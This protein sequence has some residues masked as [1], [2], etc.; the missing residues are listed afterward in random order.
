MSNPK[1]VIFD[2]FG[3]LV[4]ITEGS[5]PF[6]KLLKEGMRQGR[7][8]HPE[9]AK[10]LMTIPVGLEGAAEHFGFKVDSARLVEL[11][12]LLD[13][14]LGGI[15][16]YA[17]GLVSV[18]MLQS[19][20]FRVGVCSNLAKPYAK[21]IERIFPGLDAYSY[22]FEVGA[23]KPDPSIYADACKKLGA[24][25]WDTYM[26]GDSQ[27]CD[28]DGPNEF[29]IKGYFLSRAGGGDFEDLTSF[30]KSIIEMNDSTDSERR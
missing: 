3:T 14:E 17:D 22:S 12:N 26:I 30:A 13:D 15:Q 11:Q 19:A 10:V 25:P 20:G 24:S 8:P 27:R 5:H 23:T 29:G 16:A 7:R 2:A 6:R 1:A 4:Q 28:R 18:Q 21:A 9:D